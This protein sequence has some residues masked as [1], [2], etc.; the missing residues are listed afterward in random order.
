MFCGRDNCT[1]R[2]VETN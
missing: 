2:V 1:K